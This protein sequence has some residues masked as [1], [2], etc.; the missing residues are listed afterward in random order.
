MAN[1]TINEYKQYGR[2]R[3]QASL[4]T[5][6]VSGM[7]F[8]S[9][10]VGD[11]YVKTL[12]N[13]DISVNDESL[14]P[15][16]GL[17]AKEILL[18]VNL[19][20]DYDSIYNT[21][22]DIAI[23]AAKECIESDGNTYRQFIL[24]Q[25]ASSKLWV[26]TASLS[27]K[28]IE[29]D[30]IPYDELSYAYINKNIVEDDCTFFNVPLTKVHGVDLVPDSQVSS[31]VGSFAF[32]NSFYYID[33]VKQKFKH[34]V[35]D[36][37]TKAYAVEEME[38]IEVSPSE[39][40]AYGYNALLGRKMYTFANHSYTGVLQLTGVLPYSAS[41]PD[42]LLLSPRKNEDILFR[43][44]FNAAV[45]KK[46]KF[47]WEW[48]N[49]TSNTWESLVAFDKAVEYEIVAGNEG[50]I[51][52]KNDSIVIDNLEVSFKAPAE[53]IMVRVQAFNSEE[54]TNL[55]EGLD[56][57]TE[58]AMT[59]GFDFTV[60]PDNTKQTT[61]DLTTATGMTYWQNRLVVWGLPEDPTVLF[62]SDLN[63]P[64]YFPYPNNIIIFDEPIVSVKE[65]MNT[66]LVFTTS[67]VHQVTTEDGFTW[68]TTILQSNL[69]IEPWDRHLI[70]IVRNMVF[71]KSGNYYF[72][73]VP[74]SQ[75]LTGELTLAPVST[76]IKEFFN[77]FRSNVQ[78]IIKDTF[79]ITSE[80]HIVDYFNYLDYEDIHNVYILAFDEIEGYLYFD[81]AYNTVNRVWRILTFETK[82]FLYPYKHDATQT[83]TL[84]S[85]SLLNLEVSDE[86]FEY[87][88]VVKTP[89]AT[90]DRIDELLLASEGFDFSFPDP[91]MVRIYE[92][93][94]I[95]EREIVFAEV[96]WGN[97]HKL[98]F[99]NEDYVLESEIVDT[100]MD[101]RLKRKT[102][103]PEF[104]VG[105]QVAIYKQTDMKNPIWGPIEAIPALNSCFLYDF[106]SGSIG[107]GSVLEIENVQY[108]LDIANEYLSS[109]A[110]DLFKVKEVAEGYMFVFADNYI[111]NRPTIR[112]LPK[113]ST[114]K[115]VGRCIQLY[116]FD[117][118]NVEDFYIPMESKLVCFK[119]TEEYAVN[120]IK[121]TL[122]DAIDNVVNRYTFMNW[123][124][125]DSGYRDDNT[126]LN[127]RFREL[128]LQIN[129]IDGKDL[130][131]GLEFL[132]DGARRT[133]YLSFETE[134]VVDELNPNSGVVYIQT[135][136]VEN[137]V[138][139]NSTDL[140][141]GKSSWTLDQSLFPELSLWK[142]RVPVSGKGLTPRLRLLSK[143]SSR[144]ELPGINWIYRIM[145]MR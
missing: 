123:Q 138:L 34:T 60:N 27:D 15:R 16:A 67:K 96:K 7:M 99:E 102:D 9:G 110:T 50:E 17:R 43:C 134:Y 135:A 90:I 103:V 61:Y 40:V 77:N 106:D 47:T 145:N 124:F 101:F 21:A 82:N 85:T 129:N 44:H 78:E 53:N 8:S 115:T 48:R 56:P 51:R 142:V 74:K 97:D 119:D 69:N 55:E 87:E 58:A 84:A 32:G 57:V 6:F 46:Y 4:Q 18:P 128:Q 19:L 93:T 75:S 127:K 88:I 52:L 23:K 144:F 136:P 1:T 95:L 54:Y 112:L 104:I 143:N 36:A 37:E 117:S 98:V 63:E 20:E 62:F 2:N 139:P 42:E 116:K 49:L 86:A 33:A 80:F 122:E 126:Y 91:I 12:V 107:E 3:R 38:P 79:N 100:I 41:N 81:I 14:T 113:G 131:F 25:V 114:R 120:S 125:L 132:L 83:G 72:M 66:L 11:G 13:Y 68:N 5:S 121:A 111:L 105:S 76:T 31:V 59:V 24:G 94:G 64:L 29:R 108:V 140:G 71:F 45:G 70:H 39:A 141:L 35:F 65:Y 10:T 28:Y 130:Q 133:T 73:I 26:V 109:S 118:M 92:P 30:E 22:N 89:V 137:V